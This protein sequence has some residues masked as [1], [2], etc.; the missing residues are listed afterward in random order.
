MND[1]QTG[2]LRFLLTRENNYIQVN[3]LAQHFHCS[4]K[5]IRNDLKQLE[6]FLFEHSHGHL[7]KK[8]GLGVLV[9]MEEPDKSRLFDQLQSMQ[10]I[11]ERKTDRDRRMEIAYELLIKAKPL[12]T[13]ELADK[14]FLNKGTI[15]Q[16]LDKIR[17]WLKKMNVSVIS[18][19]KVGHSVHGEEKNIR[20]ALSELSRLGSQEAMPIAAFMETMFAGADIRLIKKELDDLQIRHKLSFT[21]ET[22]DRL[23]IHVLVMIK[24]VKTRQ[25]ISV[26][27]KE[28]Q[29]LQ[30]KEE[31]E[32]AAEFLKKMAAVFAVRFPEDEVYYLAFHILGAKLRYQTVPGSHAETP[33]TSQVPMVNELVE[34][35]VARM[36]EVTMIDFAEDDQLKEDLILHLSSTVN[37]ITYGLPVKNPMLQ[38]IK[39]MYPYMFDMVIYIVED[40]NDH[41]DFS[42]PEE[43][44]AYLTIHFQT[45]IE[46]LRNQRVEKLQAIVVCHMGVGVSQLLRT[47]LEGKFPEIEVVDS[48]AKY[49]VKQYLADHPVDFIVSTVPVEKPGIPAIQ[50]SPLM[51]EQEID[52]LAS[53]IGKLQSG[54]GTRQAVTAPGSHLAELMDPSLVFL[55]VE[56]EHRYEVI[57]LL[58]NRLFEQGCVDKKYA[59]RAINR[60]QL[61]DTNIGA[62][63]AIPHGSPDL[64]KTPAIAAATLKDPLDWGGGR[65]SLVFMLAVPN[66]HP[67][68]RE[69]FKELS[70]LT[71]QPGRVERLLGQ[72][73]EQQFIS[74]L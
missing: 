11:L 45:S 16:D 13:G 71:E 28:K 42:L 25:P 34:K 68:V 51:E 61:S 72:I 4:E 31:L 32:W 67:A 24:R 43:E 46:R 49:N 59:H 20:L 7:E 52:K 27:T 50:I 15:R 26:S 9:K 73:D 66:D 19:Q 53:F 21:D 58:A 35:L 47:K 48:V 70:D 1:R 56:R 23:T 8:P 6:Q 3:T 55:H 17:D 29:M 14:Y 36:S 41:F 5:T 2:L 40:I 60:E 74:F 10:P 12:T 44:A 64:I 18:K 63:I 62:G 33:W 30:G 69:I 54:S 65:V 22:F 37:R 57:E 39:Q 38:D